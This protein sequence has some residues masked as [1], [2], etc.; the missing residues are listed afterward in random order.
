MSANVNVA[1]LKGH[2]NEDYILPFQLLEGK[3][4]EVSFKPSME[5]YKSDICLFFFN[6]I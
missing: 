3:W 2:K 5:Y 6:N 4:R 1:N